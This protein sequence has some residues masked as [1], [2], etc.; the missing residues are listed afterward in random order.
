MN[1]TT[2][3]A[4]LDELEKIGWS[5]PASAIKAAPKAALTA[6][7]PA[8]L[9]GTREL[10]KNVLRSTFKGPSP[11]KAQ[12]FWDEVAAKGTKPGVVPATASSSAATTQIHQPL[13]SAPPIKPPVGAMTPVASQ[14]VPG[15]K[16][17]G[18][19]RKYL[20]HLG[21]GAASLGAGYEL[22]GANS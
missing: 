21:I 2:M 17:P 7:H 11:I 19:I 1:T 20:P 10:S 15:S 5:I 9:E 8:A 6:A 13:P 3:N 18:G 14:P 16:A 22:A 4:F 12:G